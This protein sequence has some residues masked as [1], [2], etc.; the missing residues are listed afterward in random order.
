MGDVELVKVVDMG[1]A[2][3]E[4]REEDDLLLGE[5]G[6]EVEGHHKGAPDNLFADG[7]LWSESAQLLGSEVEAHTTT[8][9]LYPIQLLSVSWT[10]CS[11]TQPFQSPSTSPFS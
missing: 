8:K 6:E 5:V 3:V 1:D 7:A 2:E 4:W 11:L 10:P 9:F